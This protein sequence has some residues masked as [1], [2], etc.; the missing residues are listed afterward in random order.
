MSS[1]RRD[2]H[3]NEQ[4]GDAYASVYDSVYAAKDY[5]SECDVIEGRL[6]PALH[7]GPWSILDLGCGTGGHAIPLAQRGHT[8][9]GVDRA[10][11]MLERANR[12]AGE[13][14]VAGSTR[15]V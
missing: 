8:I 1:R 14:G 9:T 13:A 7:A 3:V 2:F 5:A 10:T 15:F 6:M 12:K 11:V 4:F